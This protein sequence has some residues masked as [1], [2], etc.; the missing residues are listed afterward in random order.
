[1]YELLILYFIIVV[2]VGKFFHCLSKK[3]LTKS[4]YMILFTAANGLAVVITGL[5]GLSNILI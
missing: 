5:F 4:D 2:I 3:E 1:M